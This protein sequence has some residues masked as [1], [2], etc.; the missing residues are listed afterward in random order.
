M[1]QHRY[2]FRNILFAMSFVSLLLPFISGG[3]SSNQLK[4]IYVSSPGTGILTISHD[5]MN[6]S[7]DA[8]QPIAL[9]PFATSSVPGTVVTLV[10]DPSVSH[11]IVSDAPTQGEF[12]EEEEST[13]LAN[14]HVYS[15]TTGTLYVLRGHGPAEAIIIKSPGSY[16]FTLTPTP[17]IWEVDSP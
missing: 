2:R 13:P 3:C 4:S 8:N 16:M 10:I 1:A 12:Y 6:Y 14:V 15:L 9:S 11:V 17:M 7:Q 5:T